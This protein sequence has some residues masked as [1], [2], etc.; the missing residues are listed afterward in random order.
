MVKHAVVADAELFAWLEQ[1]AADLRAPS[2]APAHPLL[3]CVEIKAGVVQQDEREAGLRAILNFGHTVGHA[4]ESATDHDLPHGRAVALGMIVEG[5][6]ARDLCG[7][8]AAALDRLGALLD[9][10][11]LDMS[12]PEI[13]FDELLPYL[14]VDKKRQAGA[15]RVALPRDLGQMAGADDGY[16]VGVASEQLRRAYE[17][18]AQ[19]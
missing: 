3:R 18:E 10:L 19:R 13:P 15:L 11:G 7:F 9:A 4:L 17:G 1:H 16:T 6:M 14:G 8:P 5:A 12:L 2:V